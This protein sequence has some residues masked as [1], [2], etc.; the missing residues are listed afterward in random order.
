MREGGFESVVRKQRNVR[1]DIALAV[2]ESNTLVIMSIDD[3]MIRTIISTC[4]DYTTIQS[5]DIP[6]THVS[7]YY[8][9]V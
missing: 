3:L 7:F 1:H 8:T 6:E 2:M 4:F 9:I 5:I